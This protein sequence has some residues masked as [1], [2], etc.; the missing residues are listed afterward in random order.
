VVERH[1]RLLLQS[2]V[3][4]LL[5]LAG[6][7]PDV[8]DMVR[9]RPAEGR[10][11]L[12]DKGRE[13][14]LRLGVFPMLNGP[15]AV[16]RIIPVQERRI[17][18][19]ALGFR[20]EDRQRLEGWVGQ[21]SG[22]VLIVGPAG[23]GKTTTQY[24]LLGQVAKPETNVL[25]VEAHV[26]AT[27]PGVQ[28][29]TI[30]PQEGITYA[31]ALRAFFQLLDP[32]VVMVGDVPD[33]ETARMLPDLA[34]TGHLVLAGFRV[35]DAIGGLRRLLDLGADPYSLG[36]TL[37]GV[38]AQRLFRRIC[39][40]CRTERAASPLSLQALGIDPAS[41]PPLFAG[42][43]C[44]QCRQTGFK[45]RIGLFELLDASEALVQRIAEDAPAAA[46]AEAA[47]GSLTPFLEDARRKVLEG[48]TTPEE[49]LRVVRLTFV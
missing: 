19:E 17:A 42:A 38:C 3:D 34:F 41:A 13:F 6:L 43:G 48:L 36:A 1:P 7:P 46:L 16:L 14:E 2:V 32:D 9:R 40:H 25:S 45:G 8:T 20:Q 31:S 27:I 29:A 4:R 39:P 21:P 18:L 30:N 26:E 37:R 49:A 24:A 15:K 33:G 22:L 28:Q 35:G 10:I 47:G 23:V 11:W 44:E 5:H 12:D